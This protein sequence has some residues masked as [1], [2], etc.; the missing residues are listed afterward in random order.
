MASGS[1]AERAGFLSH[2]V[3]TPSA[4]RFFGRRGRVPLAPISAG[5]LIKGPG[6]PFGGSHGLFPEAGS[7]V[8]TSRLGYGPPLVIAER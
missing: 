7:A 1:L 8:A 5:F 6:F 3:A 2:G 4:G